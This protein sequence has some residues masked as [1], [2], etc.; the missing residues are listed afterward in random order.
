ML[1]LTFVASHT[2]L[3]LE[4][5]L[6]WADG[7]ARVSERVVR[8]NGLTELRNSRET[9][10]ALGHAALLINEDP[11][12]GTRNAHFVTCITSDWLT[13]LSA[14]VSEGARGLGDGMRKL[15]ASLTV[16]AA[17]VARRFVSARAGR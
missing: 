13:F 2:R 7:R 11:A 5:D 12:E 6:V 1:R 16:A 10:V 8:G 4:A 9:I 14:R 3:P 17:I 15:I